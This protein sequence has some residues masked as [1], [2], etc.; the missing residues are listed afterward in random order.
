M[1]TQGCARGIR[2]S[3]RGERGRPSARAP[4]SSH[5]RCRAARARLRGAPISKPARCSSTSSSAPASASDGIPVW[6]RRPVVPAAEVTG[7]TEDGRRQASLG[8]QRRS[9]LHHARAAVVERDGDRA[10]RQVAVT[11]ARSQ[12]RDRERLGAELDEAVEL[13]SEEIRLDA[14]RG[15]PVLDRV[16]REDDRRHR[17]ADRASSIAAKYSSMWG[18]SVQSRC[19][20]SWPRAA[21]SSRR[22]GSARSRSIA[23]RSSAGVR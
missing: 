5:R 1:D 8:E 17:R 9:R 19:H 10:R 20:A 15:R 4:L 6:L 3:P 16:V 2:R 23:S 21:S 14:E 13:R 7:D 18:S 11:K 12:R 22:P